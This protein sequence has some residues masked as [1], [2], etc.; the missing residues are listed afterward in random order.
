MTLGVGS[1]TF[2]L[3]VTD[4]LGTSS[5]PATVTITVRAPGTP[6]ARAGTPQTVT[7]PGGATTTSVTLDGSASTATEPG[8]TLT[9]FNWTGTPDPADVVQPTVTLGAGSHTFSLVVTDSLGTPSAPATV[10]ITVQAPAPAPITPTTYTDVMRDIFVPVCLQCHSSTLSGAARNAAPVG[11][12][13]NTF[14]NATSPGPLGPNNVR[15]NVRIQEGTMPPTGGLPGT[16][17]AL[18][19]DWANN[20]F[21]PNQAPIANAG[22]DQ[23]MSAGSLVTLNGLNS[24]DPE[25]QPLTFA[26]R[27]VSGP[28]V[29]LSDPAVAQPTLTA[30]SV[31]PSGANLE[32]ELIVTDDG[33]GILDPVD[34]R[35]SA[36]DRVIISVSSTPGGK[37]LPIADAGPDQ[38][39]IAG[40]LVTLVGSASR[41]PD[42]AIATFAWT[43]RK[44]PAVALSNAAAPQPTFTAPRVGAGAVALEFALTVTDNDGLA[45]TDTVIIN[46]NVAPTANA[47]PDQEVDESLE[48]LPSLVTL[49]GSASTD[50]DGTIASYTWTQTEGPPVVLDDATTAQPKFTAP[51]VGVLEA[52][53]P[54][55]HVPGFVLSPSPGGVP[56]EIQA[57]GTYA[58]GQWTIMFT[59]SLMTPDADGDVQFDFTNPA[60]T[61]LFSIAYLDNTGAAPPLG[62]AAAVMSTQDTRAYTLGNATSRAN[63]RAVQETPQNCSAFTGAPLQTSPASPSVVPALTLRAA[64]DSVNVYLCV[65]A[66]GPQWAGGRGERAVGICRAGAYRLAAPAGCRQCHGR[67]R[68]RL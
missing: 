60:N 27:Q 54:G 42:G 11:V 62:D 35:S 3:V 4:S 57:H 30:P 19:Q 58:N 53:A 25:E 9:T 59:R 1:H 52:F 49:D 61:Y 45:S 38:T 21:L 44:G 15:A 6:I 41:D 32:F 29:T 37:V 20:G 10:T 65:E 5:A 28:V 14:A 36:P 39:V 46:I 67:G 16:L 51:V 40:S 55:D 63:L 7:L 64:Y 13:F 43:Q 12:D 66:P 50:P 33:D 24:T 18:M 2:T 34:R 31:G 56:P 17:R 8:V 23:L 68:G 47:G 22:P 26:W 48:G